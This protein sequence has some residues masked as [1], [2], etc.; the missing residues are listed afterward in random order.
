ML[1]RAADSDLPGLG[2]RTLVMGVLNATIDSFSGDGLGDDVNALVRLAL[3]MSELGA[4]ILD[5]GAASSRPGHITVPQ[6]LERAR[7]RA[8]VEAV[9]AATVLPISID[10]TDAVVAEAA[11]RAGATIVNDVSTLSDERVARVAADHGA[12]L[13]LVHARPSARSRGER[14]VLPGIVVEETLASLDDA[15]RRARACGVAPERMI[16]DPGLGFRKTAAESF[17]LVRDLK[18]LSAL[19][20][21]LVGPSR[22]AHLAVAT[23]RPVLQRMH[24]T[25]ATAAI[26]V[27]NG[28]DAVRTH[29]IAPVVDAVRTADAITR[30]LPAAR[31]RIAYIALGANEG[32]A[33]ATLRQ[34]VSALRSIGAVRAVGGLWRT[35][36]MYLDD[37]P[38]FLNTVVAVTTRDGPAALVAR[39]K[40]IERRL[41][42]VP[43]PRN[44]P[45]IL[46]LD[47]VMYAGASTEERQGGVVVPHERFAE[48]RFVLGPLSEVA[49]DE[50]DPRSGLTVRQL[51]E[52]VAD[53]RAERIAEGSAWWTG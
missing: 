40:R 38:E 3:R 13:L 8:T 26:S 22:K 16:F 17:A 37:Q 14:D 52:R 48:R 42:R 1:D 39:L 11:L 34:A 30:G 29:D 47:L 2:E 35:A 9:R 28:A 19:G 31:T 44:G 51:E 24:A 23:D 45:R 41:G 50:R 53:Q 27:A 43:G 20:P 18:R 32:D 6:D 36:P 21:V 33:R 10:T 25:A 49:P 4:D 15:S 46:D 5:V 12:W 7:A